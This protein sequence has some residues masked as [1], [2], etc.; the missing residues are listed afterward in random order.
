MYVCIL[1]TCL[2]STEVRRELTLELDPLELEMV[3]N[4]RVDPWNQTQ[5]LRQE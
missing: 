4:H 1:H 5:V 3:V 2:E